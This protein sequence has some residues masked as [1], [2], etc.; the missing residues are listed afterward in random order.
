MVLDP[1][2]VRIKRKL[3]K[4]ANGKARDSRVLR[5]RSNTWPRGG[6]G[7]RQLTHRGGEVILSN[8]THVA[9]ETVEGKSKSS[10]LARPLNRGPF[11]G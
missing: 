5:R 11:I 2:R 3:L 7:R 6:K 10:E 4:K 9:Q 1:T 8:T